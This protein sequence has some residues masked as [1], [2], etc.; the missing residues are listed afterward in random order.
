[1]RGEIISLTALALILVAT[2]HAD[3]TVGTVQQALKDQGFYY[4]EVTGNK[5]AD[6]TAAIRR[7]QIRNGLQVTGELNAETQKSL[8]LKGAMSAPRTAATPVAP[9]RPIPTVPPSAPRNSNLR[10]DVPLEEEAATS[11]EPYGVRPGADSPAYP[12]SARG[13]DPQTSGLFAGTPFERAAAEAQ[14][15][16]IVG[17]QSL[18]AR[19]GYYRSEID[20]I[21]GPG[22][23]FALRAYQARF[24]IVQSGRLDMETLGAL[25]LLPGQRAPGVTA[26]TRR[27][28]RSSP[29]LFAPNGE[30]IYI[31]R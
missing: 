20:G 22:L 31:P 11:T 21:Y 28:Y 1:M 19:R 27:V 12:P 5:D 23:E 9:A 15:R 6:T 26:P 18:L 25:G 17:A 13:S 14:T 2:V 10:D 29:T 4:G 3:T 8:G 24:G 16:V 30:R 7:Y